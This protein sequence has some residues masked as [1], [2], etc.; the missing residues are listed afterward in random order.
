MRALAATLAALLLVGAVP[1]A[2]GKRKRHRQRGTVTAAQGKA[3][4]AWRL[5]A[6]T[7]VPPAAT[8]API[9]TTTA[10]PAATATATPGS[11]L[12]APNSRSVSVRSTEFAFSLSQ[13]AVDAGEVRI[14]FDNSRAEDP[15][16][17]SIDG[18]D[19]DAW[20]FDAVPAETVVA[21]TL[22][23]RPGRHVLFCPISDHQELGM[24]ATLTAR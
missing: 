24:R 14:Q 9:P 17:L 13:T 19:P 4:K 12:P 23:L 8:A 20:A 10:T 1:A 7:P 22:T 6:R 3:P 15:H 2:E 16:S 21:Y 5:P 11:T 18:P